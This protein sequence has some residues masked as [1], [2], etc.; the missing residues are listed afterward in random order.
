[1]LGILAYRGWRLIRT[2]EW[3]PL[4]ILLA[5]CAACTAALAPFFARDSDMRP[6]DI[7]APF[8]FAALVVVFALEQG[9]LARLAAKLQWLGSISYFIYLNHLIVLMLVDSGLTRLGLSHAQLTPLYLGGLLLCSAITY[10]WI[11]TPGKRLIMNLSAAPALAK[12]QAIR[13]KK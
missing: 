4:I 7:F 2:I 10:R 5:E 9:V 1:M 8:V 11:E 6:L 13:L 3:P 12:T